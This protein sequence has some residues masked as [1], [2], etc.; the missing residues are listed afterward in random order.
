M[1]ENGNSFEN[2]IAAL[3]QAIEQIKL[4]APIVGSYFKALLDEGFTREEALT[5]T[6]AWQANVSRNRGE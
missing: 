3:D 1:D 5:I 2:M 4:V 6:I